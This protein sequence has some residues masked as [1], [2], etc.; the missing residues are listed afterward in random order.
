MLRSDIFSLQI[1]N[2][3]NI[4]NVLTLPSRLTFVEG[5]NDKLFK[6]QISLRHSK[7]QFC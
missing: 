4:L 5:S 3:R 2:F 1:D 7:I 6:T